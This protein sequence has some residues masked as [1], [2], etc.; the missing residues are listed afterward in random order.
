MRRT[1]VKHTMIPPI[2]ISRILSL[3]M[4]QASIEIQKGFDWIMIIAVPMGRS[5]TEMLRRAKVI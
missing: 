3:S 4:M 1:P 5:V 2:S